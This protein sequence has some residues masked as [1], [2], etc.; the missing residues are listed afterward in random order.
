MRSILI[1]LV[2][3]A[4]LWM[5]ACGAAGPPPPAKLDTGNE[6]CRFCRMVVSDPRRASQIVAPSEE[7]LF[8]DDIGCLR[9]YLEGSPSLPAGATAYVADHRTKEWIR[10]GDALYTRNPSV[11]TPMGSG[12]L[13]YSDAASRDRDPE[14]V[15][16]TPLSPADVFGPSGAP[17][18]SPT[19]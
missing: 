15:E 16:G 9:D 3:L 2:G 11:E 5:G 4:S 7:P 10:A 19:R 8:F 13:A 12:L 17:D 18:G 14:A 1:G 6:Q